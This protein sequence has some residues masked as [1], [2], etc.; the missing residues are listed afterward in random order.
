MGNKARAAKKAAQNAAAPSSR[1]KN[2]AETLKR[3]QAARAGAAPTPKPAPLLPPQRRLPPE[4]DLPQAEPDRLSAQEV[5]NL[6]AN[7]ER[8]APL[9]AEEEAILRGIAADD[10]TIPP[11][12][13]AAAAIEADLTP[14]TTDLPTSRPFFKRGS[15]EFFEQMPDGT[16]RPAK[17]VR[18]KGADN[19]FQYE[20]GTLVDVEGKVRGVAPKEGITGAG[21]EAPSRISRKGGNLKPKPTTPQTRQEKIDHLADRIWGATVDADHEALHPHTVSQLFKE[22]HKLSPEER[23]AIAASRPGMAERLAKLESQM[24]AN[25]A[26][27]LADVRRRVAATQER[28]ADG[29]MRSGDRSPP[30][31]PLLAEPEIPGS[32]PPI[33]PA[34]RPNAYDTAAAEAEEIKRAQDSLASGGRLVTRE[35]FA[36]HFGNDDVANWPLAFRADTGRPGTPLESRD[37]GARLTDSSEKE[38]IKEYR[39][40]EEAYN[41]A[42]QT[43]AD[44]SLPLAQRVAALVQAEESLTAWQAMQKTKDARVLPG[45]RELARLKEAG[46]PLGPEIKQLYAGSPTMSDRRLNAAGPQET[47]DELLATI[48][49]S[50]IRPRSGGLGRPSA[51]LSGDDAIDEAAEAARQLGEDYGGPSAEE[52]TDAVATWEGLPEPAIK[53]TPLGG[54][55]QFSRE[56]GAVDRLFTSPKYGTSNPFNVRKYKGDALLIAEDQLRANRLGLTPGTPSWDMARQAIADAITE[57]FGGPAGAVNPNSVAPVRLS[58]TRSTPASAAAAAATETNDAAAALADKAQEGAAE[59]AAI[60]GELPPVT[61]NLEA[62]GVEL[63]EAAAEPVAPAKSS[64][65]GRGSKKQPEQPAPP[66]AEEEKLNT[67]ATEL[68]DVEDV[69]GLGEDAVDAFDKDMPDGARSKSGG[70]RRGGRRG[71]AAKASEVVVEKPVTPADDLGVVSE[72][73]AAPPADDLGAVSADPAVT[74]ASNVEEDIRRESEFVRNRNPVDPAVAAREAIR[75]ESEFVRNRDPNAKPAGASGK[76]QD[77]DVKQKDAGD[78]PKPGWLSWRNAGIA[79]GVGA[80]VVALN[81]MNRQGTPYIPVAPTSSSDGEVPASKADALRAALERVRQARASG[82]GDR[83]MYQTLSNY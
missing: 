54:R 70:R 52:L 4:A 35:D 34:A 61:G 39:R 73:A 23:A 72:D 74:P 19:L 48:I 60:A 14:D 16:A 69:D 53:K 81:A 76:P 28:I 33:E 36:E 1:A 57:R 20:D 24:V 27:P 31:M 29:Q 55:Q 46:E 5:A 12:E 15:K 71:A 18:V 68:G 25:A 41:T 67:S 17:L 62:G 9:T 45:A 37:R 44:G 83:P 50:R 2:W 43:A 80:G 75:R 7:L 3:V 13:P 21:D 59:V 66:S 82:G 51:V 40:L 79:G 65:R 26:D 32:R 64:G 63:G 11:V 42:A 78:E 49:G 77:A 6:R 47:V 30:E 10:E 8:M 38:W 58:R 22:L 56:A